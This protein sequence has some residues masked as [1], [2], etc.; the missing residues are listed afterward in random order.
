MYLSISLSHSLSL[1]LSGLSI[2]L[3][4]CVSV[5]LF[6]YFY[7]FTDLISQLSIDGYPLDRTDLVV[8]SARKTHIYSR[9]KHLG[10]WRTCAANADQ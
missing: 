1:C 2:D 6:V 7:L 9:F 8:S 10:N 5:C 3:C 4:I